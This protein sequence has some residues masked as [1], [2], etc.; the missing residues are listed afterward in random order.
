LRLKESN[1]ANQKGAEKRCIT[2]IPKPRKTKQKYLKMLT[3]HYRLRSS[4]PAESP[5]QLEEALHD[6][7]ESESRSATSF[8]TIP[9]IMIHVLFFLL[10]VAIRMQ[11]TAASFVLVQ[12]QPSTSPTNS[13]RRISRPSLLP[14]SSSSN[15]DSD[16]HFSLLQERVDEMRLACLERD[17]QRPPN[18][19]LAPEQFCTSLL[20][21][22]QTPDDPW[23]DAGFR[24]LLRCSTINWKEALYQSVGAPFP[25]TGEEQVASALASAM[26]SRINRYQLLVQPNVLI[27]F[28]KEPLDFY[29][30][31]CWIECR[32]LLVTSGRKATA[33]ALLGFSLLQQEG[34]WML[35]DMTWQDLR[36][37]PRSGWQEQTWR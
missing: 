9:T 25:Q 26:G 33:V 35:D 14:L 11:Q 31:T 29:D 7:L 27:D 6:N 16:H 20:G 10:F 12:Q 23:P 4:S 34:A 21:A 28:P 37:Q 3:E 18:A 15:N 30:G 17:W 22:L 2:I 32:L 19:A 36:D 5:S 13:A 1:S 24:T 8:Q